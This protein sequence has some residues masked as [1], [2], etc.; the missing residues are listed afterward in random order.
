MVLLVNVIMVFA[1][2][3]K[4]KQIPTYSSNHEKNKNNKLKK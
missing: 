2:H 4:K 3:K 1:N